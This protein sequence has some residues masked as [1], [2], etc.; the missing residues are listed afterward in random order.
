MK[1]STFW[2]AIAI[3]LLSACIPSFAL[4]Q[5]SQTYT[6]ETYRSHPYLT[7]V[8]DLDGD[9]RKDVIGHGQD[10]ADTDSSDGTDFRIT[11]YR[12]ADGTLLWQHQEP[13][14]ITPHPARVGPQGDRGLILSVTSGG[15]TAIFG[16]GADAQVDYV[17]QR[18]GLVGMTGAGSVLW[19][20]E[21]IGP[22]PAVMTGLQLDS[23]PDMPFFGGTLQATSSSA[24]DVLVVI[25][26]YVL[27][28]DSQ[29]NQITVLVVDGA[30]GST[31]AT[32]QAQIG[33]AEGTARPAPDL[34]GDGLADFLVFEDPSSGSSK[35]TAVSGSS[36]AAL[37][38]NQGH[39]IGVEPR[40]YSGSAPGLDHRIVDLGDTSGDGIPDIGIC[41]AFT[42]FEP[43]ARTFSVI[44]GAT[45][46]TAFTEVGDLVRA[47]GDVD[48]DGLAEVGVQS[49]VKT[50][51]E[52]GA[53]YET[54]AG[55]G[56]IERHKEHTVAI[57]E[58]A[59]RASVELLPSVGDVDGDG[60]DD[61]AHRVSILL[62]G[63]TTL[64]DLV[65][66]GKAY[67]AIGEG[68]L[69]TALRAT[70]DGRGDDIATVDPF[71]QSAIDIIVRD[72]ASGAELWTTRLRP[73]GQTTRSTLIGATDVTGDGRAELL[74]SVENVTRTM[75]PS[76]LGGDVRRVDAFVLSA[77]DG[78]VLWQSP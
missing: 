55:S 35:I 32:Y 58:G 6:E 64:R 71:G 1:S 23:A 11:A 60:F 24:N 65:V 7:P 18:L 42:P 67:D 19:R 78:A 57:P 74:V 39:T 16:A 51:R 77:V 9:G 21:F 46:I 4:A 40:F 20:R 75:V 61:A 5:T 72:G 41:L 10:P 14:G 69:A 8:N 47:V 76:N 37:W 33:A 13:G 48:G 73:R 70:V 3:A 22:A 28:P 31:A 56:V 62:N 30:D 2:A 12:G 17:P 45:G 38:T 34:T 15:S 44:N 63:E 26:D 49:L 59:D 29:D 53:A 54:Y 52:A 66:S 50:S 25:H 36:G 43:D 27:T 68:L